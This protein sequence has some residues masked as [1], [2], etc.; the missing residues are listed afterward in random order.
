MGQKTLDY[1]HV[2]ALGCDVERSPAMLAL[3]IDLREAEFGTFI[4]LKVYLIIM[5]IKPSNT[6]R[7]QRKKENK[8]DQFH[9][10]HDV[11]Q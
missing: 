10:I 8:L 1:E 2:A 9:K 6:N 4:P 3:D 5:A 7:T 11:H